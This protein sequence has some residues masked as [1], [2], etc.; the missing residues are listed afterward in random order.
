MIKKKGKEKNS[1][2]EFRRVLCCCVFLRTHRRCLFP[3]Y[4]VSKRRPVGR[5]GDLLRTTLGLLA[6]LVVTLSLP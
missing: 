5:G 3:A 2:G 6:I 4:R 1:P